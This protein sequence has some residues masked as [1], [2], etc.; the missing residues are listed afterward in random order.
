V[1]SDRQG[2][3]H[4]LFSLAHKRLLWYLEYKFLIQLPNKQLKYPAYGAPHS[5]FCVAEWG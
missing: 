4:A 5:L 3:F 1:S 2:A